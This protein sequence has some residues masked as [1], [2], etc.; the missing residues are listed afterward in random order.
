MYN[1]LE[2]IFVGLDQLTRAPFLATEYPRY[3]ISKSDKGY[4]LEMALPGW[5]AS[6]ISIK[7]Q[8][9]TLRINGEKQE[10]SPEL[11]WIHR[12]ISGKGFERAFKVNTNLAVGKASF[13][14]GILNV[15]ME[16]IPETDGMDV[17]IE[18]V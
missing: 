9:G 14:N 17:P 2:K 3:N 10:M 12:G 1:Q 18:V 16:Y 4:S 8:D 5:D 15:S 7:F 13:K 6:D 11:E